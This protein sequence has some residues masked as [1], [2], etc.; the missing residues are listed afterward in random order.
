MHIEMRRSAKEGNLAEMAALN[1]QFHRLI[2]RMAGS[3]KL[4]AA[5][6]IVSLDVPRDYLVQLPTWAKRS[7]SEHGAILKAMRAGDADRAE[8]LMTEHLI[9]SGAGLADYLVDQGL[10]LT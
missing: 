7:I 5:L 3:R 9:A 10:V 8:S 1:W 2:N 6:R 4:L